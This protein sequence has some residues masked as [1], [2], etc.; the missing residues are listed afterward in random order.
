MTRNALSLFS[1]TTL[2]KMAL[3]MLIGDDSTTCH[4]VRHLSHA[5]LPVA[6]VAIPGIHV[7][8]KPSIVPVA[9][10]PLMLDIPMVLAVG[11]VPQIHVVPNTATL[12]LCRLQY[13]S[14]CQK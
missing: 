7:V 10:L 3:I 1:A 5:P 2:V 8:Q 13:S 4:T 6:P 11:V 12:P 14:S 9:T